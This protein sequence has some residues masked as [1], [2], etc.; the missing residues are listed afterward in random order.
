MAV[1]EMRKLE[2]V[3]MTYE[4]DALLNAL[5][6][7]GAV[8]LTLHS[9]TENTAAVAADC[10]NLREYCASLENA[11]EFLVAEVTG[12]DKARKIKPDLPA[13]GFSVSYEEF[14][15]AKEF[16]QSADGLV[17]KLNALSERRK[18]ANSELNKL[19]RTLKTA[20]IYSAVPLPFGEYKDT[21]HV[22]I[23]LGTVPL[24]AKAE[25]TA[26]AGELALCECVILAE[27]AENALIAFA[28]HKTDGE[29]AA[30]LQ[31]AGFS[32]CPFSVNITGE[33][34]FLALK[35]R[36]KELRA[37][38]DGVTEEIY[39]LKENIKPLKIYCDYAGF[40]LEK[41]ELAD[42]MRATQATVFIQAYVPAEAEEGVKTAVDGVTGAVY[43]SFSEPAE[44][45]I[46]P[47]LYKNSRAV[48]NFETI[49]DMYSPVNSREFDPNTIMAFF[50]SV[51]LGFIMADI[52]YGLLMILGG[53]FLWYKNRSRK[54]TVGSL[55]GVFAVGGIFTIIWGFLF[56]SFFGFKLLPFTVMPDLSGENMSW[57]LAG[58]NV[59]ALLLISMMI[60]VAQIFV[61]YICRTVQC[62]RRGQFAD[63]IFDGVVW[64][65]F[66]VGVEIAI[67]GFID[68]FGVPVL[69]WVGGITA[70]VSLL[71]AVLTA[72]RKEKLLGKF[73]KGF[74]AAYGVINY[75]SDILSYA[76]LYGLMLAG[77]VIAEIITENSVLL[78]TSGNF[79]FI[80]LGVIIMVIGHIFNLAI[81]LLGAYIHDARLQYVEFYGRFYEGEGEL[82]TPL[83]SKHKHVYIE[84]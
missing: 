20:E 12:Y 10:E 52:G 67:I 84:G 35:E 77:A 8:E 19:L 46:P 50:Y 33:E 62:W 22:K 18:A 15:S 60:G 44:D 23:R 64:A 40:L 75:A 71:A 17:E 14:V 21:A 6:R 74:G 53:G 32:V 72:G 41:A 63:G 65:I 58:I 69:V 28:Y 70:G 36:E 9:E 51:F 39:S 5:E 37:E 30:L 16:K 26:K 59:P 68:E 2:L 83:G 79:G 48:K 82:F 27:D 49:T 7:T 61:G 29:A 57:S 54:T 66:S 80:I 55:G 4:K 38:L 78:M 25:F 45:E 1:A 81:G 13:D 24:A 56:N 31:A 73:T 11:L 43:Y 42:K 76:R 47:T 3:A 34:N